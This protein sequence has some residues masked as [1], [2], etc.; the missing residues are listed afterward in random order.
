ML[1]STLYSQS[2]EFDRPGRFVYLAVLLFFRFPTVVV[3]AEIRTLRIQHKG[4]VLTPVRIIWIA[5][6]IMTHL[7]LTVTNAAFVKATRTVRCTCCT[8]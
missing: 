4:A 7:V 3:V 2:A 1:A 8:S 6:E 5:N